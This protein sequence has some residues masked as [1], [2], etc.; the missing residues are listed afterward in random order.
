MGDSAKAVRNPRV[1]TRTKP[2]GTVRLVFRLPAFLY[3]A[4][5]GWVLGHRFLLLTHRGRRSG[6]ARRT[7]L[8]VIRYDPVTRESLVLSAWGE[9]SDWY[10]NLRAVPA[11]EVRTGGGRYA[12]AQW[13]LDP[14]EVCGALAYY[15]L[16]HPFFFR[17]VSRMLG[18][19]LGSSFDG[20]QTVR[21]NLASRVR[22][23][24]FSPT[25]ASLGR[26]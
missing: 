20:M 6:R 16:R 25:R 21:T 22:M 17:L 8:E 11:M 5:L 9:D 3:S 4:N 15:E 12:P 26:G 1:L 7:V 19:P 23:V 10:R 13:F 2:T 18:S 14:E 24:A